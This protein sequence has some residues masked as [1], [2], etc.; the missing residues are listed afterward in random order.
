[1][2]NPN[3]YNQNYNPPQKAPGETL[4][5]IGSIINIAIILIAFTIAFPMIGREIQNLRMRSWAS[6]QAQEDLLWLQFLMAF[7]VAA[8]IATTAMNIICIFLRYKPRY[9]ILLIV[10]GCLS[11]ITHGCL[12]IGGILIIVGAVKNKKPKLEYEKEGQYPL[13]ND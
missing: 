11:F 8:L 1:M 9:Y 3:M 5:L 13:N 4:I 12:A 10:L 6:W 2:N 7:L